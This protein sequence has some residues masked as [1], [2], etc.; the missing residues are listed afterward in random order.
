[1]TP[2][3][4]LRSHQHAH[5]ILMLALTFSTGVVDAVGFLGLDRVFVGNMTGNVV[6]LGMAMVGADDLP[7][8]GP[9]LALIGFMV[10]AAGAGRALRRKSP[11]SWA[12]STTVVLTVVGLV[13]LGTALLVL[14][15]EAMPHAVTLGVTTL[16]GTA[17]GMQA[18]AARMIAVKDVTTVVVTSSITGLAA[19]SWF[20]ANNPG[21]SGRR[22]AA[23]LVLLL[24]A[25]LGALSLLVSLSLGLF[26]SAAVILAV[27][28][29]GAV[30]AAEDAD[31]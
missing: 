18:A 25:A 7:V 30:P 5:L 17:M 4:R 28:A 21:G 20:G 27:A 11:G 16:L 14:F 23:V 13:V 3:T 2:V 26:I 1:M 15:D 6:I 12:V 29:F 9:A 22:I 10:G 31:R 24:G 19:D 8:L